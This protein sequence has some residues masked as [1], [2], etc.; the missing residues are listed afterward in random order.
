[1]ICYDLIIFFLTEPDISQQ[2]SKIESPAKRRKTKFLNLIKYWGGE[3]GEGADGATQYVNT[4]LT[5]NENPPDRTIIISRSKINTQITA[6]TEKFLFDKVV[7]LIFL[8][9]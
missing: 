5:A 1:M 7:T 2:H 9:F 3:R 4:P 6:Q 8:Y